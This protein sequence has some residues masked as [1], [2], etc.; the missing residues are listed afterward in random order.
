[1][2]KRN[3]IVCLIILSTVF[4]Y[5][6]YPKYCKNKEHVSEYVAGEKGIKGSVDKWGDNPA[7]EIGATKK[8][9]A[10]FKNPEKAFRQMKIDFAK[11][12]VAIQKEYKFRPISRWNFKQYGTYGCQLVKIK[13]AEAVRQARKVSVFLD[14]YENSFKDS[15]I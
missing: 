14:I 10:V 1:M 4:I 8:G 6:K 7:Y 15:D 11:G 9:Y 2:K 12:I 3:I 5:L 13:D